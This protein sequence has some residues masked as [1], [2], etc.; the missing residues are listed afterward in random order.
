MVAIPVLLAP[1][2]GFFMRAAVIKFFVVSAIVAALA[3]LVPMVIDLLG[4]AGLTVMLNSAFGGLPP[5]VWYFIDLLQ[6]N[7]GLPVLITAYVSRFL[8]R[9]LP[10]VG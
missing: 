3:V 1:V 4:A 7:Y 6:F 9:R 10:I 5:G 2:A 8:I